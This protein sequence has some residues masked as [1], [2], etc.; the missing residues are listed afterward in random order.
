MKQIKDM[1][2]IRPLFAAWDEK[3]VQSALD[4]C[5]GR[6]WA[7]DDLTAAKVINGDF[8]ALAGDPNAAEAETLAGFIPEDYASDMHL[9]C[10]F[11]N[12]WNDRIERT[13]G[14]RAI[15]FERYAIRKEP[16]VF[17]PARLRAFCDRIPDGYALRPIDAELYEQAK[18]EEW[19]RDF[20]S[21]FRDVDDYLT[22]GLGVA[23]LFEGQ[24]IA[25]ASSYVVFHDGI[26]IEIDTRKDHRRKGLALAC[27]SRLILT[28]LERNWYPSWDAA[29][30]QSVAL[31]EK[32]GY[33]MDQPYTTYR[34][35]MGQPSA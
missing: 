32:L 12:L 35:L 18:Q 16:D 25:G 8:A 33:H 6:A 14:E 3:L 27:A 9:L 10:S 5:M 17:D 1:S 20:V 23:V 26:E 13:Y 11:R 30:L 4:G 19:S 22:R 24:M 15:G 2:L 31:A 28:C 29:N 34:I 21:Q 7:T